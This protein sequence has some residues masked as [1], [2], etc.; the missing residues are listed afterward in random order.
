MIQSIST[1]FRFGRFLVV[2]FVNAVASF[3]LFY[4]YLTAL[5][6]HYLVA[7]VL[8]FVTWVWFGFELQ[9]RWTF[10]AKA[11]GVTFGKFLLNQIAFLGLGSV[12]LWTLVEVLTVRAEFAYLLTLGIV[13]AG[14]Y[15]S[16]LLWVFRGTVTSRE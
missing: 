16:S 6:A 10:R 3:L 1:S 8:V 14:M 11:S 13:T 4:I 2:G 7:N 15:L 12:L 9:R 5:G